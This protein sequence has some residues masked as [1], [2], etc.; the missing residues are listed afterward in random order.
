VVQITTFKS[1]MLDALSG[2]CRYCALVIYL[3]SFF[4]FVFFYERRVSKFPADNGLMA[5]D[6]VN[7][8]AH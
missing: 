5:S 6:Q 2:N 1:D 3:S 4:V 7:E 8:Q